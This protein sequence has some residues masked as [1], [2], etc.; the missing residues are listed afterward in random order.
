MSQPPPH[1][2]VT[3]ERRII[4]WLII[5]LLLVLGGGNAFLF[6]QSWQNT[7]DSHKMAEL[8]EYDWTK[9]NGLERRVEDLEQNSDLLRAT[10]DSLRQQLSALEKQNASII[11]EQAQI[12][13]IYLEDER[14]QI[15]AERAARLHNREK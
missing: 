11:T 14:A 3:L 13:R 6:M 12:R 4:Q 1:A 15:D 5:G 7:R 8:A 9:I 10:T 2:A